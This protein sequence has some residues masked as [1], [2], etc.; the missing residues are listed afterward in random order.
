MVGWMSPNHD[1]RLA[2]TRTLFQ[3]LTMT[4]SNTLTHARDPRP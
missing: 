2:S 1:T 4:L 3:I